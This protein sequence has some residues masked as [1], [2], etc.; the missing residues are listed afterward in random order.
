[1]RAGT[2]AFGDADTELDDPLRLGKGQ[3]LRV[4]VRNDEIHAIKPGFDHVVD[5]VAATTANTEHG[6]AG[7]ELLNVGDGEVDGHGGPHSGVVGKD[8]PC[9]TLTGS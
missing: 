4:G 9:Q 7:L 1:M 2:Q 3:S 8:L 6:D 5:G